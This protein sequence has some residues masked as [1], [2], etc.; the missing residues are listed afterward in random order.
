MSSELQQLEELREAGF[1]QTVEYEER[2]AAL[3][4]QPV[5]KSPAV[6]VVNE[7]EPEPEPEHASESDQEEEEEEQQEEEEV[8]QYVP[9]VVSPLPPG[10][11]SPVAPVF[12]GPAFTSF[13]MYS[14]LVALPPPEFWKPIVDIKRNHMNPRI[15]RPP[16]PHMTLLQPFVSAD[17]FDDAARHLREALRGFAP[18][19]VRIARF[20]IYENGGSATLY[21][22]PEVTPSGSMQ[23]LFVA[24]R[25]AFPQLD[26]KPFDP[27]IGVGYFRSVAQAR[28]LQARY[29]RGW[30]TIDFDVKEIYLVSRIAED[31]PFEVRRVIAL[32]PTE[33]APLFECK[34]LY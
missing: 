3:L 30:R 8:E 26:P 1:I 5:H 21:L 7:P 18:F 6:P 28:A 33:T 9:P 32:G 14:S 22:A 29:Q 16:Y 31:T 11:R 20:E 34:S 25:A 10:V 24:C 19:H 27:H 13:V 15:K 12:S 17:R 4:C 2:R 23:A